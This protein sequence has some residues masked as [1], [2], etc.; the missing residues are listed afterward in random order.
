MREI[1]I[2]I[3]NQAIWAPSA[4][5]CQPWKFGLTDNEIYIYNLPE[6]DIHTWGQRASYFANGALIE[7]IKIISEHLNLKPNIKLFP[8]IDEPNLVAIIKFEKNLDTQKK[9]SLYNFIKIRTTNRKA[10]LDKPL[11]QEQIQELVEVPVEMN[12]QLVL[13]T[14][15]IKINE[16]AKASSTFEKI[17]FSNKDSH[18]FFFNHITWNKAEEHKKS[19]GFYIK[20]LELP[21]PAKLLFPLIKHWSIMKLLNKL[22]FAEA[23][24]KENSK[25]YNS[26]SAIGA[27]VVNNNSKESFVNAGRTMQRIWLIAT[28]QNLQLQPL[29]GLA[30]LMLKVVFDDSNKMRSDEITIIQKAYDTMKKSF[31][32]DANQIIVSAFRLGT[33]N[34]PSAKSSRLPIIVNNI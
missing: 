15:K 31:G 22:K 29:A 27:I 30:F 2:T 16:L 23:I 14:D 12:C 7:N 34:K 4:D 20:T 1:F 17:L 25:T 28:K 8:K 6:R 10:Y 32:L 33:G 19:I 21:P 24:S 13:E 5:N 9:Q 3:L 18:S 26:S 11:T